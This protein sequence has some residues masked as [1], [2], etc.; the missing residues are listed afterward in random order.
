MPL[1]DNTLPMMSGTGP[2]GP[3][4]MGG[5]FTTVKIRQ[6]LAKDDYRDPGAYRQP[7]GTRAYEWTGGDVEPKRAPQASRADG[8]K[9][10]QVRKPSGHSGH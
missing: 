2:Y 8:A 5:M 6:G 3:I 1:P 10:M 9:P 4:E 7:A